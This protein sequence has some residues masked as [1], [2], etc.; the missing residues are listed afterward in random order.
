MTYSSI[1]SDGNEGH[2]E[3][4]N[5]SSSRGSGD[6]EEELHEWEAG[7]RCEDCIEVSE[8]EEKH[9][10]ECETH[11]SVGDNRPEHGMWNVAFWMWHFFKIRSVVCSNIK[12]R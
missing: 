1:C 3:S 12:V 4:E 9:D 6:V 2:E 8:G 10:R 5:C 11:E 7:G